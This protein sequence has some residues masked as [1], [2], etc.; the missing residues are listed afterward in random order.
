MRIFAIDSDPLGRQ[1]TVDRLY[2]ALRGLN[3]KRI[4]I[5]D[6]DFDIVLQNAG[7]E[8][9]SAVFFGPGMYQ[10]AESYVER[11]R[12][13]FPKVPVVIVLEAAIYEQE[14]LELRRYLDARIMPIDDLGQIAQFVLEA[15]NPTGS[16]TSAASQGII[17]VLQAKGGVGATTIAASLAACWSNHD[18]GVALIELDDINPQLSDWA[19]A[20][21]A[22]RKAVGKMLEKGEV[23][24][25]RIKEIAVPV[26]GYGQ[27]LSVI[28]LPELYGESFHLKADI[29]QSAPSSA[30]YIQSLIGAVRD[31]FDVVVVDAG[32]SWG[33]SAFSLLP[34]SR[35]IV[36]VIDDDSTSFNRTFSN[37]Q[38]FYRESDDPAEFDFSRWSIV[39][40]GYTGHITDPPEMKD[41]IARLD[42][43][44]D[45]FPFYVLP[46]SS[47]GR[48]WCSAQSNGEHK[49]FYDLA[50]KSVRTTIEQ[51][52]YE[53]A[54]FRRNAPA[55][56]EQSSIIARLISKLA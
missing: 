11:V 44:P 5:V 31:H 48:D 50:D 21:L 3:L 12:S 54:P 15:S 29:I 35:H 7:R 46:F 13:F 27:R 14:A 30:Q 32:K 49:T 56:A 16:H 51:L 34:L 23:P 37:I 19:G 25:N 28:P 24:A 2:E 1:L 39:L 40:N 47:S 9:P 36:C 45:N 38:R 10:A 22:P 6:G 26:A 55:V 43:L 33:V 18:M 4:D 53:L 42:L 17:T 41:E 52:A 8:V 20:G